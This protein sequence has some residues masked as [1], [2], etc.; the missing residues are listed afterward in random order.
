MRNDE[1]FKHVAVWEYQGVG[2]KPERG[3]EPLEFENVELAVR[4]YK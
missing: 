1:K 3:I 2:N 4:S